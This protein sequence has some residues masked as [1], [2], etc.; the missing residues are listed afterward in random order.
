MRKSSENNEREKSASKR[1]KD[2]FS[3]TIVG[4][5]IYSI[6]LIAIVAG[7][8]IG[9]KTFL[10]S[11][12]TIIDAAVAEAEKEIEDA[13][14]TE[15]PTDVIK[16]ESV[17]EEPSEEVQEEVT[18]EEA[19]EN[20]LDVT[21]LYN[22]ETRVIDYSQ[23]ISEPGER[24]PKLAWED[25]VFS[26]IEN[27]RAPQNAEVN[28]Y[29]FSRKYAYTEQEKKLEFLIYTNPETDKAEKITT[30]EYCGEDIEVTNYYYNNGR[31]NY[32]SQYRQDVDI[33]INASTADVQSRYY[34]S[35]D[36][37]VKFLFCEGETAT[38]YN[39]KEVDNFSEGTI[40][41]YNYIEA[42]MLNKAYINYNVIRL[43]DESVKLEGYVC[44]EFNTGLNEVSVM[45]LNENDEQMAQTYT[46]Q[47]GYY[48][49]ELPVNNSA[50]YKLVA[51]K[52][53][54]D[55]VYVYNLHARQGSSVC[56]V[57]PI[58]MAYTE[59]GAIYNMQI[60]V[61]DAAN[62]VNG[63]SEATIRLRNGFNNYDGEVIATGT[64]DATGA[65]VCPM[66]AGCYTAEV[67]KGGYETSYF[68]IVTKLDH[69]A[70]L[71]YGVADVGENQ[72]VTI[73]SWDTTPL[74]LDLRVISSNQARCDRSGI[75]SVG[76]TMAEMIRT[77]EL[78]SDT[79]ECFVS[80][81]TNCTGGDHMSYGMS[82]SNAYVAVYSADGLQAQF[83]VPIAHA[84]VVWKPFEIRNAR[85]LDVNEY[86][87]SVDPES[88]WMQKR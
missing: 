78:G 29:I 49:I 57:E 41:Q 38:E 7:T 44:D 9:V 32:I 1:K 16:E 70:V 2:Q 3:V 21:G 12:Q 17:S 86:Y 30:R 27:I 65:I 69:Q 84:G 40:E 62:A 46:T 6:A 74:D 87:Y 61:R 53:T 19:P 48:S 25:K 26:K 5:V 85:I 51:Q 36:T 43:L 15:T 63:L 24:N 82:G 35:A 79:F 47:D 10:K 23:T 14:A 64:L 66:R 80:D 33:P 88:I 11:R 34:Y 83:H 67:Q 72:V 22:Q 20:L 39:V 13:A 75:D 81:F 37:L 68:S 76:S 73:L 60:F 4:I 42:S 58:Y 59:N 55:T 28:N 52:N 71:G 18:E 31:I 8:Y 77:T 45:I 50:T 56:D 54:L